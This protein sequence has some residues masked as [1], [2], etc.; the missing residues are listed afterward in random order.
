MQVY[1]ISI[2]KDKREETIHGTFEFP[3]EIYETQLS[4]NVLGYVNW[5]WHD[6]LQFC[7]VTKGSVSFHVNAEEFILAKGEGIYINKSALHMSKPISGSDGAYICLDAD[8]RMFSSFSKS[9]VELKYVNFLVD[10]PNLSF[11]VVRNTEK[12]QS[13]ILKD[14]KKIYRLYAAKKPCFE[15]DIIVTLMQIWKLLYINSTE[16]TLGIELKTNANYLKTKEIMTYIQLNYHKK[17]HLETVANTVHLSKSECCR[18]FKKA[19]GM[20]IFEYLIDY[21]ISRAIELLH[22]SNLN[23]SQIAYEVGFNSTSFFIDTFKKRT[24][25]TPKEYKKKI[26]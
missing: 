25:C 18:F 8:A 9:A 10:S 16:K 23:I 24:A 14:L 1:D 13:L 19:S 2:D 20:T 15:I 22:Y 26:G 17:I 7:L 4:K 5:H 6:E 21:R 12:W 11:V 3:M